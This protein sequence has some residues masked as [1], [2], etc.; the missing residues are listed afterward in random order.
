LPATGGLRYLD[1]APPTGRPVG[2]LVLIHA[3]PLSAQMWEPQFPLRESGWRIVAPQLRG[4]GEG[5]GGDT[6]PARSMDDYAAD[7]VDL[8]DALKIETA[9]IGGLSLGG[10]VTLALFRRAPNYFR[11]MVLADTRPQADT[12]E[13]LEGR[14]RMIQLVATSGPPAVA[15][16]MIPKLLGETTR[17]ENP[18]AVERV[19]QQILSNSAGAID[20]AIRAMM[21][22]PDST[23]LLE[24][25]RCPTLVLVGEEDALTPPDVNRQMHQAI[26]GSEF[27][28]LRG[29]GHLSNL[30][31]PDAF[32]AALASFL[33]NRV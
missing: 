27:V 26:R 13:G 20:G 25:I 5:A 21:S 33:E 8:L 7:I 23:P 29:A 11:A 16:E 24:S 15:D 6:Q 14:K 1:A 3:F 17:R 9:V 2:T 31:Q 19:R 32:N 30:E 22:R 4:F 10:Y 12:P 18:Q 28:A